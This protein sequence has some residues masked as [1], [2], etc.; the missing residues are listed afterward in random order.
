MMGL[1]GWLMVVCGC[2]W[3]GSLVWH[4]EFPE[5][6]ESGVIRVVLTWVGIAIIVVVVALVASFFDH[7][8]NES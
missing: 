5:S 3:Y 2:A 8:A 1:W 6:F 4:I 7:E